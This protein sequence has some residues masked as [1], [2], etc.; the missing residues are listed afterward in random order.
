ML[1]QLSWLAASKRRVN[2]LRKA[3]AD[4]HGCRLS[5]SC[6]RA[7]SDGGVQTPEWLQRSELIM[8]TAA[9]SRLGHSTVTVVGMGGVGSWCAGSSLIGHP[10]L[11][12]VYRPSCVLCNTH[13]HVSCL[14]CR[15]VV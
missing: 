1:D 11:D 9:L 12:E 3:D 14:V 4:A 8:G 5:A 7:H 13:S 15:G 6:S 2:K 10:I